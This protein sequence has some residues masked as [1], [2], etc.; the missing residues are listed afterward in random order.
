[1]YLTFFFLKQF[2]AL[3]INEAE[4]IHFT[5]MFLCNVYTQLN[6]IVYIIRSRGCPSLSPAM[7]FWDTSEDMGDL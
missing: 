1:M 3:G 6:F 4:A 5:A 7:P 2:C